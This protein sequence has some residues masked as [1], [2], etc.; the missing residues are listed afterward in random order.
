MTHYVTDRGLLAAI[1]LDHDPNFR[2]Y[3]EPVD[4]SF[5][6]PLRSHRWYETVEIMGPCVMREGAAWQFRV[7]ILMPYYTRWGVQIDITRHVPADALAIYLGSYFNLGQLPQVIMPHID[8]VVMLAPTA[9]DARIP[10][11]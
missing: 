10:I 8:G 9:P 5:A 4:I 7:N 1:I 3:L 11:V 2:Q 6:M